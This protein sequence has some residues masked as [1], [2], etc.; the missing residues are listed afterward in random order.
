ML[1]EEGSILM[2]YLKDECSHYDKDVEKKDKYEH[3]NV[4][5]GRDKYSVTFIFRVVLKNLKLDLS[6]MV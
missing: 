3:E 1:P 4:T 5:I 2:L 6:D